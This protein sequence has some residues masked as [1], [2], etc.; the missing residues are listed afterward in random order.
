MAAEDVVVKPAVSPTPA[1]ADVKVEQKVDDQVSDK[2]ALKKSV[3]TPAVEPKVEPAEGEPKTEHKVESDEEKA[4]RQR[5]IA[6]RIERL[7]QKATP[8]TTQPLVNTGSEATDEQVQA[9]ITEGRT[10]EAIKLVEDRAGK[11]VARAMA[12]QMNQTQTTQAQQAEYAR[13]KQDSNAKVWEK[14]PEVLEIDELAM[15]GKQGDA[16]AKS[17]TSPIYQALQEVYEDKPHLQ[18]LADGAEIAL[19]IAERRL[20]IVEGTKKAKAEGVAQEAARA[21][22]AEAASVISPAAGGANLPQGKATVN[23]SNE[24]KMVARKMGLTEEEYAGNVSKN[25]NAHVRALG[26]DYYKKYSGPVKRRG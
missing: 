26:Q 20:G 12:Q 3:E 1:K 4:E 25:P 13:I 10:F 24:E 11:R 22:R 15:S 2:E 9:L 23:L 21:N 7:N 19:E 6:K 8:Q 16:L 18:Y 5:R 14:Y 17:K